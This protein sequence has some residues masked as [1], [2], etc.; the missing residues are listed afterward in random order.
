LTGQWAIL[1]TAACQLAQA[2]YALGRLDEAEAWTVRGTELG[3]SD[4]LMTQILWRQVQ[5]KVLARRGEH[6]E[7]ERLGREAV[8]IADETDALNGRANAYLDLAEV[9]ELAG[10][11]REAEVALEEALS[12]SKRKGN[13]VTLEIGEEVCRRFEQA[14]LQKKLLTNAS[15]EPRVGTARQAHRSRG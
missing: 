15:E 8:A 6:S 11:A 10:K 2:L 3:A 4:D 12:L 7:A 5:A 1:S 13:V 14:E 9:L